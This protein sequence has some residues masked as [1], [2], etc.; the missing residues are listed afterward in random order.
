VVFAE[1]VR[2]DDELSGDSGDDDFVRFSG[3]S[4][5]IEAAGYGARLVRTSGAGDFESAARKEAEEAVLRRDLMIAAALSLPVFALEMG[6][7]VF[8][9]I[10]HLIMTTI[11]MQ[12]S[13]AL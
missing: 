7:H 8:A 3:H 4:E 5:A 11:G 13:W 12:V 9:P 6:S 2:N 10:H 1:C